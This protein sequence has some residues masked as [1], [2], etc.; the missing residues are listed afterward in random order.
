MRNRPRSHRSFVTRPLGLERLQNRDLLA[1]NVSAFVDRGTLIVTGDIGDNELRITQ[2]APNWVQLTTMSSPTTINN[3]LSTATFKVTKGMIFNMGGGN[4]VLQFDGITMKQKNDLVVDMGVGD[5]NLQFNAMNVL[6]IRSILGEGHDSA[7]VTNSKVER[8]LNIFGAGGDDQITLANSKFGEKSVMDGNAGANFINQSNVKF[9]RKLQSLNMTFGTRPPITPSQLLTAGTDTATVD[10]GDDVEINVLANDV[11]TTGATLVVTSLEIT[12]G[13]AHGTADFNPDGVLVYTHNGS[14]NFTD[15]I[16]Y[17]IR[18]SSGRTATGTVNITIRPV[19]EPPV[20]ATME[21]SVATGKF[22]KFTVTATDPEGQLDADSTAIVTN[23]TSGAAVVNSDGS[24]T[25]THNGGNSTSDF[26]TY[27]IKDNAGN[28]SNPIRVNIT[29]VT[30]NTGPTGSAVSATVTEGQSTTINIL[31]NVTDPNEVDPTTVAIVQQPVDGTIQINPN[32]G[33]ITYTHNGDEAP[34]DTFTF[35]VKDR[36]G[37]ESAPITV[38]ITVTPVNDSPV[39]TNLNVNATRDAATTFNLSS[40]VTDPDNALDLTSIVFVTNPTHGTLVDNDNGTVT[41]TNNGN[42]ATTDSFTYTIKD[43]S[44]ATSNTITVNITV[45]AAG[46]L[47]PIAENDPNVTVNEGAAITITVLSNDDDPD[48]DLD[49]ASVTIVSNGQHGT[50]VAQANGTIIYTHNGS[51]TPLTDTFTYTVKDTQGQ[52]SNVAT[53]TITITPVNDGPVAQTDSANVAN[54]G[55]VTF[56]VSANDQDPEGDD[57]DLTSIVFVTQ[58]TNGTV[59]ENDDGTVTYTH[60]GSAT[61]T[62]SFT[63]NIKDEFGAV[64]N[65]VTVT[66]TIGAAVNDPPDANDDTATVAEGGNVVIDVAD[67]DT[68]PENDLDLGS[69]VQ[70]VAPQ[71]GTITVNGDGTVTYTHDGSETTTD[72]FTYTIADGDGNVSSAATVTITIN[73]V[74]DV[75][76]GEDDEATVGEGASVVIDVADN[77]TDGDGNETLDL[78]SIAIVTQG[79]NGT[80]VANTDGTITYTHGGGQNTSD[81]FTYTIADNTGAVSNV[82]TVTVTITPQNDAPVA[83]PDSGVV[84]EGGNVTIDVA[85]NDTDPDGNDTL[86]LASIEIVTQGG[87]GTAVANSDGTITYTHDGSEGAEDTFTYTIKDNTGAVSNTV[88]VTV[89]VTPVNDAPQ[90]NGDIADVNEGGSV[91]IDVADNDN[92][93]EN[94]LDLGSIEITQ[95]PAHGAL[96]NNLDGTITYVHDGSETITDTFSYT[97]KDGDGLV[98]GIATVTITI[99]PVNEAPNAEDDSIEV[100]ED[101][102]VN[103][104]GNVLTNDSDPESDALTVTA[105]DDTEALVGTDVPGLYGIFRINADGTFTYD[106]DDA[107]TDVNALNDGDFLTD[108]IL[109][110]IGDGELTAIATLSVKING[111]T[112]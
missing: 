39:G 66:I 86:D 74:N 88:T 94:D 91:T 60:N 73:P 103:G 84:V 90:A 77:D 49:F 40:N 11:P 63:Y 9:G 32:T 7:T 108:S 12:D 97:I 28:T 38:N 30:N 10:E 46:N 56:S 51:E 22:I 50:A 34:T 102:G 6:R 65:T 89:T 44:G 87:H 61:T 83:V 106:L 75:P 67:N 42:A 112:D 52:V 43:A 21:K 20:G 78:A 3:N 14:E 71:H 24:I 80:A 16:K 54:G 58:P 92:D 107:N 5:D 70:V 57:L 4:D 29:V 13:P 85:D 111:H 76:V 59:V 41:Y 25:Y 82:V 2:V 96:T 81:T 27:T 31:Q 68:D 64:S 101:S 45:S 36:L 15:Q 23:G 98:S 110:T 26:F 1:G 8:S 69:I 37:T 99:A 105:V 95:Q 53:V 33:V 47:A 18:D 104:S 72:S 79:A 62:D 48:G 17:T 35:T 93:P 109:Y 19:N 100:T 55:S